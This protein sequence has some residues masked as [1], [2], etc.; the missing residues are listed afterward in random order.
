VFSF[1]DFQFFSFPGGA[2]AEILNRPDALR[3]LCPTPEPSTR[4]PASGPEWPALRRSALPPARTPGCPS[5]SARG[6]RGV[7]SVSSQS[8]QRRNSLCSFKNTNINVPILNQQARESSGLFQSRGQSGR[9]SRK[10]VK[11]LY[12]ICTIKKCVCYC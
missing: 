3:P 9:T 7:S 11:T 10:T 6:D 2:H 1:S 4:S 12:L 8:T 5:R